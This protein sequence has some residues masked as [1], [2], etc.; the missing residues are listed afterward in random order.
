ME[1]MDKRILT[2]I[3]DSAMHRVPADLVIRN[4]NVVDVYTGTVRK[5]A[6]AVTY[7]R[8]VG[9]GEDYTGNEEID[10]GGAYAAPG[11][12]D[13]HIHIESSYLSPEEFG[14]MVVPRGTTTVIADP[15]EIVNVY[16]FPSG[17]WFPAAF[18]PRRWR[19]PAPS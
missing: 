3:I 16:G 9:F 8:I 17:I 15:H 10:A 7:G 12:I 11:L 14:R 5:D 4:C 18:P 19:I 2:R 1:H 6:I 13:A